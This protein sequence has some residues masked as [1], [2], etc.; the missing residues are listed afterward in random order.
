LLLGGLASCGSAAAALPA[1]SAHEADT[2]SVETVRVSLV[3]LDRPLRLAQLSDIHWD[4]GRTIRWE[5]IERAAARV[6]EARA[7]LVV[8]TGDYVN[9]EPEPIADLAPLLGT[10]GAPLGTFAVL[11]NHDACLGRSSRMIRKALV[12]SGVAVLEN[13]WTTVAGIALAG[14]GD[15]WNGPYEPEQVF[16]SLRG[17]LPTVL[18]AHNPDGFWKLG[19]E[20]VDLQ[21]SGHTHGGQVRL[22]LVGPVLGIHN[23]FKQNVPGL[24]HRQRG[25]RTGSWSGHYTHNGNRLYVSRGLGRFRRLSFGCPPEVTLID[26]IPSADRGET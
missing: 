9:R 12:R 17:R 25:T 7:D 14:V 15:L 24:A 19:E 4:G 10:L 26:L 16:R 13:R 3:G 18:L 1:Y 11:G 6:R 8:L 22:P 23:H 2:L 20:R 5:L 21:L